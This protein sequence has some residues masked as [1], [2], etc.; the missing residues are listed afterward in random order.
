MERFARICSITNEG[1]NEGW[2]WGDG[3]FYTKYKEDTLKE[4]RKDYPEQSEL[5]DDELLEWAVEE[6]EIL[7][8]TE[9]DEISENVEAIENELENGDRE[10]KIDLIIELSGDEYESSDDYIE[11]AKKN[12]EQIDDLLKDLLEYYG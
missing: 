7:Y 8:W 6:E 11:L 1:M 4:L 2:C 10:S 12:D 9:W 5:S 3:M